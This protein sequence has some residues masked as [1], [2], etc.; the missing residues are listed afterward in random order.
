MVFFM[1][2]FIC[3]LLLSLMSF[4]FAACKTEDGVW[5]GLSEALAYEDVDG[6]YIPKLILR[7]DDTFLSDDYGTGLYY[8]SDGTL[9]L[10]DDDGIVTEMKKTTQK[11]A[12]EWFD[13]KSKSSQKVFVIE[14]YDHG[15]PEIVIY[16]PSMKALETAYDELRVAIKEKLQRVLCNSS[17]WLTAS[18][19]FDSGY[20]GPVQ[21]IYRFNDDGT[22]NFFYGEIDED[23]TVV[24]FTNEEF[25]ANEKTWN[26]EVTNADLILLTDPDTGEETELTCRMETV[27][28]GDEKYINL[29]FELDQ[30]YFWLCSKDY[31]IEEGD[32]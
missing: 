7:E 3:L 27:Y 15:D 32:C 22:V 6:W 8:I 28:L 31:A 4:L 11:S 16:Y 18:E 20:D 10:S 23:G 24:H 19:E 13:Y 1:K 21:E 25:V 5:Y 26:Y 30:D 17:V 2:K 9:F 14:D 12:M 29:Y